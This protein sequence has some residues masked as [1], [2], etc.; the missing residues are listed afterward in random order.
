MCSTV[1][2]RLHPLQATYTIEHSHNFY[3]LIPSLSL[4]STHP[5][6]ANGKKG[7]E[8]TDYIAKAILKDSLLW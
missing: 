3:T 5:V 4:Y 6:Q 2:S 7:G 8:I 1:L